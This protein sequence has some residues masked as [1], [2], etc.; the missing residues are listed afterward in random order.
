MAPWSYKNERLIIEE[1]THSL[2]IFPLGKVL[3]SMIAGRNGFPYW[4]LNRNDNN[5]EKIF[6]NDPFMPRVNRILSQC[7][8][9]EESDC[10]L[11]ARGL[12]VEVD[13]LIELAGSIGQ[14]PEDG[15]P[16]PCRM[17]GRGR[18]SET[19]SM[20]SAFI[21]NSSDRTHFRVYKCD[22]CAHVEAFGLR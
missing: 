16:W 10:V 14:R 17:C 8:V 21:D 22:H 19:T 7:I 12:L 15:D 13:R 3:W 1:V 11:S 5:L 2:D 4:E 20:I 9:R 6:P 18:Y